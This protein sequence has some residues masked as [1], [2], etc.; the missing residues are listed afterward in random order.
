MYYFSYNKA[1]ATVSL[2]TEKP[3]PI[4]RAISVLTNAEIVSRVE[5][6][7][8]PPYKLESELN[9]CTRAVEIR[10]QVVGMHT[11]YKQNKQAKKK[12][13]GAIIS[14]HSNRARFGA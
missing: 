2:A 5:N 4:D 11:S 10:R 12:K 6:G 13:E 1:A 3:N 14:P 9:D 7:S 8:L